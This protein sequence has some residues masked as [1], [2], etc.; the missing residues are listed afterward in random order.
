MAC[1]AFFMTAKG[2]KGEILIAIYQQVSRVRAK[3]TLGWNRSY[4]QSY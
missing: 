1:L 3:A 4:V 2:T